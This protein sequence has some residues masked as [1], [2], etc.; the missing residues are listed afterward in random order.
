MKILIADDRRSEAQTLANWLAAAGHEVLQ[1][2]DGAETVSA[3]RQNEPD[4]VLLNTNFPPDVSHGGGALTDGFLI[5]EWLKR[6]EEGARVRI[7]LMTEDDAAKLQER[8]K[9]A[10]AIGLFQK[11]VNQEALL[12]LIQRISSRVEQ[13]AS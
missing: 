5:I 1:A 4:L 9:A 11:P 6:M 12:G 13:A 2:A 8:A 3:V 7:I 10:G